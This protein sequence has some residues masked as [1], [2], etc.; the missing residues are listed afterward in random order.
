MSP[1]Q[2]SE[3]I[4]D[5]TAKGK[6][7]FPTGEGTKFRPPASSDSETISSLGLAGIR[8]YDAREFTIKVGAGT[9]MKEIGQ[10]LSEHDQYLPFDSF[11]IEQGATVGGT[12]ASGGT[13][14]CRLRYGSIKDFILGASWLDGEGKWIRAGGDV[15]KNAAGFDLP[16]FFVGSCG[17]FGLLTEISFKVFPRPHQFATLRI[18]LKPNE[19]FTR[20]QQTLNQIPM[21]WD[22]VDC[23]ANAVV[24]LRFG[25]TEEMIQSYRTT[26]TEAFG[27]WDLESLRNQ[28]EAE[29]WAN[30]NNAAWT[31]NAKWIFK[32]PI[33]NRLVDPLSHDLAEQNFSRFRF[34]AAGDLLLVALDTDN[35]IH[36]LSDFLRMRQ[37]SGQ[38]LKGELSPWL[39]G[40]PVG[41]GFLER[42][43]S[44]MDPTS[45]YG[46]LA[47]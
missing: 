22:A 18:Q 33:T 31:G 7:L 40:K 29:Y 41:L 14:S 12:V 27:S 42:V 34:V 36:A 21:E 13:G 28:D 37:L 38:R 35:E 39:I 20:F 44:A 15:V 32:I 6:R 30:I 24:W 3:F 11:L 23:D 17:L 5:V 16:K 4:R 1:E 47:S 43:K 46:E 45:V 9:S 2:L 10:V 26:L 19:G 25:G 8:Q